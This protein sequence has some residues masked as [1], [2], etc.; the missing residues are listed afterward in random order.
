MLKKSFKFS[1]W[2]VFFGLFFTIFDIYVLMAVATPNMLA[3]LAPKEVYEFYNFYSKI[4][5]EFVPSV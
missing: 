5:F 4:C 1:L 2:F 3:A